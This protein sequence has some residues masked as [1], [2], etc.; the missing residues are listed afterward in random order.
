MVTNF[1]N[2]SIQY[3]RRRD[4]KF[5]NIRGE[6]AVAHPV[7]I[8][9]FLRRVCFSQCARFFSHGLRPSQHNYAWVTSPVLRPQYARCEAGHNEDAS[10]SC[11]WFLSQDSEHNNKRSV[12]R[13]RAGNFHRE[14]NIC[15]EAQKS[16][17]WLVICTWKS[18]I[19]KKN[20]YIYIYTYSHGILKRYSRDVSNP[21]T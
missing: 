21:K 5:L 7:A 6:T 20:I 19:W 8:F 12:A 1:P 3:F 14:R 15:S 4:S 9:R 11:S 10:T 2:H 18:E 17:N 16:V 13:N